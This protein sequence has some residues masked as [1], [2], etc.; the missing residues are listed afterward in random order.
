ME[1]NLFF[2]R[3]NNVKAIYAYNA[4]FDRGML[5]ELA[6]FTWYDIM[7]LA[8]YKKYN[9]A[10]APGESCDKNGRLKKDFGV[11]SMI[12]RMTGDVSFTET[13]NALYDA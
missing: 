1:L 3:D 9:P 5:P 6:E 13:H 4:A 12:R 7:K 10:I 2:L 11:G 8:A